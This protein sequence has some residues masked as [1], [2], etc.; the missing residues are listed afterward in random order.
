MHHCFKKKKVTMTT[1][2]Y[3]RTI[4][5]LLHEWNVLKANHA[6][7]DT[8]RVKLIKKMNKGKLPSSTMKYW[9]VLRLATVPFQKDFFWKLK[10]A[11]VPK[12]LHIPHNVTDKFGNEVTDPDNIL[13]Q[14]GS[15][16]QDRL[17]QREPKEHF[18]SYTMIQNESCKIVLD[19][20]RKL[21]VQ[22]LHWKN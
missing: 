2:A 8:G 16:F 11:L 13:N 6:T 14:F 17:R 3:N 19:R 7:H 18:H 12:S 5:S 1:A 10:R 21:R 9:E 4:R 20:C 22:I 15:E